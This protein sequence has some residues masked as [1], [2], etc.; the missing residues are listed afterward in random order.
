MSNER[1][2]VE[3]DSRAA[4]RRWLARHHTQRDSIWLVFWKKG[5]PRHVS[6]DD[7]VEEA[8]CFG[9]IDSLPRKL[10]DA[11]SMLLLSPRKPRSAWSKLNKARA[12]RMI[13][14]GLMT[15]AGQAAIDVAKRN[16]AW[17]K[18]E[19]VDTLTVPPDLAAA[20]RAYPHARKE[21]DAFPPSVR[22]GILEWIGAAKKPET[23]AARVAQTASMAAKGQRANQWRQPKSS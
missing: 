15:P 19:A 9:W 23:R 7:I 6:N 10:D 5:H 16:G 4:W 21:W 11:R 12:A 18:L 3:I 14:A 1:Q 22:R 13:E 17:T 20:L 8:L 2:Q